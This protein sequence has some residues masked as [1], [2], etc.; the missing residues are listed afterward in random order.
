MHLDTPHRQR[1][2]VIFGLI[3]IAVGV[4]ALLDNLRIFPWPVLRTLWPMALVVFGVGRLLWPRHPGSWVFG[5]GLIGVGTAMTLHN[6]GLLNVNLHDWWP[7]F[8]ILA[9]LSIVSRGFGSGRRRGLRSSFDKQ[10]VEHG[11]QVNIDVS[12]STV[13]TQNDSRNFKGGR[14]SAQFG[15]VELD[16]RQA[17]IQGEAT[18]DIATNFGGVT[19]LVPRDWQVVVNVSPTMGAVND[20]TVPPMNPTQRLLL[21]GEAVFGGVEIKH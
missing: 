19:L 6:L 7:V 9:G 1:N 8:I 5:A 14:I 2:R 3:V 15:G 4:L 10:T 13:Q 18:L 16:L 21:R 12:F 20:H 17:A 11:D